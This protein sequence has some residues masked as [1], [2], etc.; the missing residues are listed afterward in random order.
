MP[1]ANV[2]R[3]GMGQAPMLRKRAPPLFDLRALRAFLVTAPN[4]TV[5]ASHEHKKA[6]QIS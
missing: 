1:G 6:A 2:L 5:A 4:A 3:D